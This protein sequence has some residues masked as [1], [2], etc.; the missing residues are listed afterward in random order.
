M[1]FNSVVIV[2]EVRDTR[3]LVG[4]V[5]DESGQVK[6]GLLD[7]RFETQDLNALESALRIKD[8][9]GGKVTA[10]SVGAPGNVD[11]L[12]ECLYRGADETL[13]ID[14]DPATLDTATT[15]KLIAAALKRVE[16]FDLVLTGM[17]VVEGESSLLG[18]HVA[19]LLGAEQITY[20][21]GIE[22]I[23]EGKVTAKRAIEM[24]DEYVEVSTPAV[25]VVGLALIEDDPRTPRSAK[26]MLKLKMKKA[27]IPTVTP[28]EL[29]V[30]DAAP[31]VVAGGFEAVPERKIESQ[32]VDADD[33]AALKTML[34]EILHG[35]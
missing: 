32:E 17:T 8:E 21:D 5:L 29:G 28:A 7:T 33:E 34:D 19:G 18:A 26:A 1:A 13:R 11:V 12:K 15:A 3:D 27:E 23:A 24:G 4:P 20:V 30:A 35:E 22:A 2:R 25:L 9:H 16:P 6:K 14:V 31:A 10:V